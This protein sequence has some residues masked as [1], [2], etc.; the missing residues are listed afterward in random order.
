MA[1]QG[2]TS[3]F[4]LNL[5]ANA[6]L[7]LSALRSR[8]G[9]LGGVRG[10]GLA[11]GEGGPA[12]GG[13]GIGGFAGSLGTTAAAAGGGGLTFAPRQ[14]LVGSDRDFVWGFLLGFFLGFVMLFWVMLPT[15]PHKQ[16]LGLITGMC[17]GHVLRTKSN[18]AFVD[19][20]FD[21]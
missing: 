19:D 11:M 16:R 1:A 8:A 6:P 10:L 9:G 15:V 3:E 2:P 7:V 14:S 20:S 13:G 12:G 21:D 18:D 4:R 17:V 5:N